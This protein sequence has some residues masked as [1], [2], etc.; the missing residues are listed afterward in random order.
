MTMTL[1]TRR[2]FLGISVGGKQKSPR[3]ESAPTAGSKGEFDQLVSGRTLQDSFRNAIR[4]VLI[5][6]KSFHVPL[7]F[8]YSFCF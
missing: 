8:Q 4:I 7:G 6:F 1:N 5:N 3:K 2:N